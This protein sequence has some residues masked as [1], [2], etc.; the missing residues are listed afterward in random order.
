[1]RL[2]LLS[3]LRDRRRSRGQSLVEFALVL[4]VL[5]LLTLIAIDFGRVYLGW[6]NL[7]QM[8]RVA[9]GYASE[10]A[11]AWGTPGNATERS[12]YQTKVQNDA[13][14]I[15]C[16]SADAAAGP[17]D[18]PRAPHWGPRSRSA[19]T[20]SS[21]VHHADHLLDRRGTVLV[22]AET[23]FPIREGAVAVV[24]GGGAPIVVPPEARTSPRPRIPVGHP[25]TVT[26]TDRRSVRRRVGRGTSSVGAASGTGTPSVS[27]GTSLSDG[28]HTVTYDCVG[29]PGDTCAFPLRWPSG[30][31]GGTDSQTQT[32]IDDGDR[33]AGDRSD[34]RLHGHPVD[35]RQ[36]AGG[37]RSLRRPSRR[38]RDLHR[39]PVGLARTTARSMHRPQNQ[40]RTYAN[41]GV[42]DVTLRVTDS[43]GATQTLTKRGGDRR[44]R[45]N[46]HRS[47][48]SPTSR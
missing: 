39:L 3:R 30:N 19:S 34:R 45:S 22:S 13:R 31:A 43:T 46:L 1:M 24:P 12:R 35:R 20:A 7:Q 33:P 29:D 8:T 16:D 26:F 2:P 38:D 9:A 28:P 48:T 23:T 4:P 25:S 36:A 42:Y 32:D 40:S 41:A 6:V 47:R 5:L 17:G 11:S 15:N 10:H 21:T 14:L 18:L 44:H 37:R 27:Q